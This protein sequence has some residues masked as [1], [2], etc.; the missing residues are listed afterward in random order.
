M[1]DKYREMLKTAMAD[2]QAL[3]EQEADFVQQQELVSDQLEE[4]RN[5][6]KKLDE[7]ILSLSRLCG[8]DPSTLRP[9]LSASPLVAARFKDVVLDVVKRAS[10]PMTAVEVR[11]QMLA[12][13]FNDS[14]YGNLLANVHVTLKRCVDSG[15]LLR[16]EIDGKAAY[17]PDPDFV[18][19]M[20]RIHT[21]ASDLQAGL[22]SG[23]MDRLANNI[24][25]MRDA[26]E[27]V[28]K[29]SEAV[30]KSIVPLT[31]TFSRIQ[32]QARESTK[33]L[34]KVVETIDELPIVKRGQEYPRISRGSRDTTAN[35]RIARK[36][37]Q[38]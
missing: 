9:V 33:P 8:I 25:P 38:E 30:N 12:D 24:E 4:A 29:L 22:M 35:Q 34:Q 7:T 32:E 1:I 36:K 11:T 5:Q 20:R 28:S 3:L 21:L 13:G 2:R 19:R 14:K 17:K 16:D 23:L 26:N 6:R 18:P 27:A 37:E 15:E 31:Q 10:A